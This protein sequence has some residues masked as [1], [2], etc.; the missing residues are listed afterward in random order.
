MC[1]SQTQPDYKWA[2]SLDTARNAV[3][4]T[5]T[6]KDVI[7]ELNMVRTNPQ[8]YALYVKAERAYYQNR[9]IR[10]PGEITIATREGVAAVDECISALEKAVPVRMLYP[11]EG[12]YRSAKALSSDQAKTGGTA[13]Q[14]SDG[15]STDSRIR[16]QVKQFRA[17]GENIHYG[18]GNA[19]LIVIR[20]LI[21]DGVSSRGHRMNILDERYNFCGVAVDSHPIYRQACVIDFGNI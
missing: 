3:Y 5:D 14:S 17:A 15:I 11:N 21:D 20:L 13:H 7:L 6:E 8:Q 16:K 2:D 18:A 10:K 12:L 19:R 9:N 4:L 1:N